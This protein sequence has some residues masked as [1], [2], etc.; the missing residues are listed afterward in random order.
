MMEG[1]KVP[2]LEN[3]RL[4]FLELNGLIAH[5]KKSLNNDSFFGVIVEPEDGA[6]LDSFKAV[7]SIVYSRCT[8]DLS[9][10]IF[11]EPEDWRSYLDFVGNFVQ[12][13]HDYG[14]VQIDDSLKKYTMKKKQE[15][16]SKFG[17]D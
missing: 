3:L 7:N 6:S 14:E 13:N 4:S 2:S 12:E 5:I 15:Y 16:Y 10:K 8:G 17:M 11:T 1:R 9:M